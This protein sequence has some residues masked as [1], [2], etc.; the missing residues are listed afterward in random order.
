MVTQRRENGGVRERGVRREGER[1]WEA[2]EGSH[3][4]L[5]QREKKKIERERGAAWQTT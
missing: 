3:E 5:T 2:G 1:G 4:D